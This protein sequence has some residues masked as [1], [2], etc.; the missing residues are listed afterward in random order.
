MD[1][2]GGLQGMVGALAPEIRG[3]EAAQ[4]IVNERQQVVER[5]LIAVLPVYEQFCDTLLRGLS[6]V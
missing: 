6:S 3:G 4:F 5:R 2:R 1:E